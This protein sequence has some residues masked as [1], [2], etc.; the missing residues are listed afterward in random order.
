VGGFARHGR[1]PAQRA[2]V[3]ASGSSVR[4]RERGIALAAAVFVLVA[5]AA[6]LAGLWYAALQEYRV[7]ANVVSDRRAFDAA[8]AGIDAELAGWDAAALNRLAV[9]DTAVFSGSLGGGATGYVG[10]VRRL[11]S[12]LFI[13]ESAGRDARGLSQRTIGAL[14]RL[15]PLRLGLDA[16]LISAGPV[17]IG[18]GALVDALSG[19]SASG[20][21]APPAGAGVMLGDSADLVLSDCPAGTCLRGNPALGV[22]PS[23]RHLAAPLLGESGWSALVAHS[24]TIAGG[25][26]PTSP[27]WYARGDLSLPAGAVVGPVVL[28]VEGDLLIEAGA[29]FAGLAVVR[30]RLI[31]RGSGGSIAGSVIA[32]GADL[33]ALG[34]AHATL[35]FNPCAIG[36]A[37]GAAAPAQALPERSWVAIYR[38]TQ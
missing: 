28:L 21:A 5:L 22:D 2:P 1:R 17:R 20:C 34:E 12:D 33:S 18:R 11:G 26:F 8:E 14:A 25:A 15:A 23:L 29:R 35:V 7:G 27:A 10:V 24:D 13:I 36:S 9:N 3:S 4:A 16:A 38:D 19:D 6:L 37:L 30:G 32:G 31:M